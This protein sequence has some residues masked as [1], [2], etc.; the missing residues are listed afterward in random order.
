VKKILKKTAA[1]AVLGMLCV[2]TVAGQNAVDLD[3]AI[4]QA[5]RDINL[6]LA[7]GPRV[8]L[9]NISSPS[10]DLSAYILKEIAAFLVGR[11]SSTVIARQDIDRT[12]ASAGLR[13]S[14]EVSD[15]AARQA[16]EALNAKFVLTGS[17]E[18]T[19]DTYRFKTKLIL[20]SN[21]SVSATTTANVKDGSRLRQLLATVSPPPT[22]TA[23]IPAP[24]PATPPPSTPA[25]APGNAT[26][27][28]ATAPDTTAAI[29][30]EVL[31]L[32][33]AE[34]KK[35]GLPALTTN[36][37]LSQAAMIRAREL[38]KVF[39]HSRPNGSSCFTVF[40]E[41][42]VQYSTAG[43]NIAQGQRNAAAAMTSWM[44]SEGH[45]ANILSR[46]FNAVGIG[47]YNDNGTLYWLQ[48]FTGGR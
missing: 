37:Q 23:P 10:N 4:Q 16:G 38:S 7:M 1:L 14:G 43:E 29:T 25:P 30:N 12:L 47:Y 28:S 32:V 13:A 2:Y 3:P 18:K 20:V 40:S 17:F 35:A 39:S 27:P 9:L 26:A 48:L 5:G 22:V 24:A 44:N 42:R 6:K 21:G 36:S 15:A 8:A 34:R 45:R 46:N 19:G 31:V 11:R 33:N 41:T